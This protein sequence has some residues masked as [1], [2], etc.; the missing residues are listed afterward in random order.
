MGED[1]L[2]DEVYFNYLK[3]TGKLVDETDLDE[4]R[5]QTPQEN[6]L[7]K[8]RTLENR[9]Q[10]ITNQQAHMFDYLECLMDGLKTLG[11]DCIKMPERRRF[12]PDDALN[13]TQEPISKNTP[14]SSDV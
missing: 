6:M 7:N 1:A 5:V 4:E 9:M 14:I 8:I 12:D 2:G 13:N 3:L 11:G 10:T